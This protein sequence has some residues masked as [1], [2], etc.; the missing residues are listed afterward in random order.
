MTVDINYIRKVNGTFNVTSER[1]FEINCMKQQIIDGFVNSPSYH[2]VKINDIN[3]DVLI[4]DE[5]ALKTNPNK[6]QVLCKPNEVTNIGDY[7]EWKTKKWL[8]INT[9]SDDTVQS[10]GIIQRCNR[11]FIWQ[12]D[13]LNIKNMPCILED[14]TSPYNDGKESGKLIT[15]TDDQ[16]LITIKNTLDTKKLKLDKRIMFNNDK[17][18]IYKISK[19]QDLVVD[20]LIY[21]TMTRDQLGTNDR[22]DLG[23]CDYIEP[24]SQPE[25]TPIDYSIL[26]EGAEDITVNAQKTYS[27]K[28]YLNAVEVFDKS[29]VW[30]L[31]DNTIASIVSQTGNSCIIKGLKIGYV[32]LK[33]SLADDMSVYQ[34]KLIR[35]KNLF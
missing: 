8:C 23:L 7:I 20:G 32:T 31:S 27:A 4:V 18:N 25:P 16:I 5:S 34:E 33:S 11:I 35:I 24:T 12:D 6:K 3:R 30:S 26:I 14:K 13:D 22:L 15:L 10:K 28:V 29:V 2:Q 17:D 1:D 19:I 9:D 21:L